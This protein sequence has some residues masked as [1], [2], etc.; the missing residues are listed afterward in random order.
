MKRIVFTLA[1][2]LCFGL[3]SSA[4]LTTPPNGNNQKSVTGQYI[5]PVSVYITY[6][7]PD[8]TSPQGQ[9]RTGKIWGQLVPYGLQNLG[10]GNSSAEFPSPW[11][12][13]ANENTVIKFSHDVE[14]QGKKIMAGKYGLH[15]IPK[16]TGPWTL[17][18]SHNSTAWGSY[19]YRQEEDALRVEVNPVACEYNEWLTYEFTDRQEDQ[20]TV[21]LKWDELSIPFTVSVPNNKEIYVEH[22]REQMQ[23]ST[24]FNWSNRNAA[25]NYCLQNDIN[26]EEALEWQE[27]TAVNSFMG[28]ENITTLQTL[29]GLQMK[30]GQKDKA[31]LTLEKAAMHP[32][33]TVFQ[34]HGMGRQLITLGEKETALKIFKLNL[35]K[36]GDIWPVNVGLARGYSAVGQY[37]AALKHAKIAYERAP[38]KLNKDGLAQSIEKLKK[39]ED[40]N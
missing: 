39:G 40:I 34:I 23:S 14:V 12:A 13:G 31:I 11:R 3:L 26:L 7:S 18:F 8:V 27:V 10:F 32:T 5:G 24:G 35:E 2:V 20:C 1:F 17:I 16:E 28:N 9:D 22:I 30:L 6:N 15:I 36:S 38:D 21:A 25:A 33:A 4:Q 37:D 19:F 29:A